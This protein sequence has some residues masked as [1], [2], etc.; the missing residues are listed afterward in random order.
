MGKN[1]FPKYNRLANRSHIRMLFQEGSMLKL[2]PCNVFY[3]QKKKE[4]FLYNK[5]LFA[6]SKRKIRSAVQ[7]N[8][9][10]RLLR[11]AY[12]INKSILDDVLDTTG[13]KLVFLIGYVYTGKEEKI[14]YPI[15]NRVVI[16]SLQHFRFL[17]NRS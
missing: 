10:K 14:H 11:E 9:V 3:L 8:N 1:R 13:S 2:H 7:R 5:V 4:L 16:K 12:R 6:V 15:L 17:L